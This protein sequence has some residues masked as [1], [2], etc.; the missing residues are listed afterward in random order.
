MKLE[1]RRAKIVDMVLNAGTVSLDDLAA[2][3]GVS[4][5]TIHRDLDELAAAGLLKKIRGGASIDAADGFDPDYRLREA[6][7]ASEKRAVAR[8]AADMVEPGQSIMIND[9]TTA[10][11]MAAFLADK[12]PLTVITNNLTVISVLADVAGITLIAVGGT[13]SRKF[14]GFYGVLAETALAG[15][16]ADIAFMSTSAVTGNGVYHQDH[17]VLGTKKAMLE[18]SRRRILLADHHKFGR[19][20][21]YRLADLTRFECVITGAPLCPEQSAPL[22]DAGVTVHIAAPDGQGAPA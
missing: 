14:N 4:R 13:Y 10:G 8:A 22:R 7:A 1:D 6:R 15:L 18:R 20:A 5:M 3:F 21:L 2:G 12:A 19:S 11:Q 16:S 17:E 9:G